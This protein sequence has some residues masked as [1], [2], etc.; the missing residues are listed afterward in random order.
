MMGTCLIFLPTLRRCN[1]NTIS[2]FRSKNPIS[3]FQLIPHLQCCDPINCC[4]IFLP[5]FGHFLLLLPTAIPPSVP[6]I[7]LEH[8]FQNYPCKSL[9]HTGAEK[10]TPKLRLPS[11]YGLLYPCF[12]CAGYSP[13]RISCFDYIVVCPI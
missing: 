3:R 5:Q 9:Y 13:M 1:A 2:L 6:Y 11:F 8:Q 4:F 10:A 12:C 7:S